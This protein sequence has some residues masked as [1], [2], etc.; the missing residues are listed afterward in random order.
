MQILEKQAQLNALYLEHKNNRHS[1]LIV[2]GNTNIIF[3]EGT[4][5]AHV[6]FVGEAPG[7][8]EDRQCRPFVGRSGQLL[9]KTLALC[10]LPREQVYI[11][12]IVKTR[13]NN[14]RTPNP[15]EMNRCW[16]ILRQQIAIIKPQ[17]IVALGSCA[18]NTLLQRQI[19]M[20]KEHGYAIPYG[21][22][23]LIVIFHPA[24]ILRNPPAYK[25]FVKDIQFVASLEKSAGK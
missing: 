22:S 14:N 3:G 11:T 19:R 18:A 10:N 13:P 25:D 4:P 17:I 2:D 15:E 9:N 21:D 24:Y 23:I 1:P 20:T 5:D 16:P 12:N 8:E 6:M 7:Q